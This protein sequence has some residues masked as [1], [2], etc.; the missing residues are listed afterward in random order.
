METKKIR[1]LTVEQEK[2]LNDCILDEFGNNENK[3]NMVFPVKYEDINDNIEVLEYCI[4]C[5]TNRIE[6][7]NGEI[8]YYGHIVDQVLEVLNSRFIE[9][10][11]IKKEN[12]FNKKFGRKKDIYN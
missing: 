2:I 10:N 7:K 8:T 12:W 1:T 5:L 11:E 4:E 6:V 3:L 9:L